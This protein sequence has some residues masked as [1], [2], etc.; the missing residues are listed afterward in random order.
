MLQQVLW[1]FVVVG[2]GIV[3]AV[4][5]AAIVSAWGAVKLAWYRRQRRLRRVDNTVMQDA[6]SIA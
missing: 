5:G 3:V 4:V 2:A 1:A 6:E